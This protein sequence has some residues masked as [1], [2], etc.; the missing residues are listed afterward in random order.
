[1]GPGAGG[2]HPT[3]CWRRPGWD[4]RRGAAAAGPDD[5]SG[6][7]RRDRTAA[8]CGS[9]PIGRPPGRPNPPEGMRLVT[10]EEGA[11]AGPGWSIPTRSGR[12]ATSPPGARRSP[13]DRGGPMTRSSAG[14]PVEG[15]IAARLCGSIIVQPRRPQE[16]IA[17]PAGRARRAAKDYSPSVGTSLLTSGAI[18]S[19][20]WTNP[21]HP[22][23]VRWSR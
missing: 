2:S 11:P 1:M 20:R 9:T 18:R 3:C 8:G 5:A 23:R 17:A 19:S 12:S 16:F 14:G 21:S 15:R 13:T 6:P 4:R 10:G 22:R 7:Y